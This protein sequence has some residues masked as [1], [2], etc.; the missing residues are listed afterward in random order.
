MAYSAPSSR[1]TGTLITASIWNQDVVD[2]MVHVASMKAQSTALSAASSATETNIQYL[3][4]SFT[5]SLV[6]ANYN[7]NALTTGATQALPSTIVIPSWV[8]TINSV[9]VYLFS[10]NATGNGQ[11]DIDTSYCAVNELYNTHTGQ[12]LNQTIT[13]TTDNDLY[14]VDISS[15]VSSLT[16]G[17]LLGLK[18]TN[19]HTNNFDTLL[20]GV[21][22]VCE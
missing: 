3:F 21:L 10:D 5:G 15:A 6:L 14:T 16:G 11:V 4:F 19:D 7:T 18:I 17:D 22:I 13:L 8:T 9:N 1:S 20:C 12:L 2:N